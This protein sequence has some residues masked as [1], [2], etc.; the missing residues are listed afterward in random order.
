[1][2]AI[3][4][5]IRIISILFILFGL[6]IIYRLFYWQI[7]KGKQLSDIAQTQYF[8][9]TEISSSRGEILSS[10]GFPLVTNRRTYLLYALLN[11]IKK[12]P[13]EIAQKLSPF[14]TPNRSEDKEENKK[15]LKNTESSLKSQLMQQDLIWTVLGRRVLPED[16]EKIESLGIEG[17]GFEKEEIRFYPEASMAANLLGFV[18]KNK[19]GRDIGY[20]G[21][22]GFYD[23][24]LRG[25]PGIINQE[26]DA[27]NKP[28]LF[29]SFL[30]R[31]EKD[32]Q[33]LILHLDRAVQFTVEEK[34]QKA[35][36][37]YGA[38]SG[39]VIILDPETGGVLA[40]ASFPS[41]DP[42]KY[43]E[44]NDDLFKNPL[45]AETYEPGSTAK[46]LVTAAA[47][48]NKSI[49]KDDI[50][51]I[52]TGP[53]KIDKYTIRTWNDEYHP[54]STI[55]Q[56]IENSDNIGMI[57]IA[58]KLGIDSFWEYLKKFGFGEKTNI[59]LQEE[60]SGVLKPKNKWGEIDLATASFGQGIAIT[61]IQMARAV[62]AIANGGVLMEPHVV[63]KILDD[64]KEVNIKPKKI[65]EVIK[66]ESAREITDI[67]VN[68]VEKGE[69][70]WSKIKGYKIAGKTGTAQI[71][72]AGHYDEEKTIASFVGFAPAYKPKFVILV[73]LREPSSS[74]W[75]AETAA[76]L[77]FEITRN[78]LVYYGIQPE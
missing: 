6:V 53:V 67:M 46:V 21:L 44:E 12:T 13:T 56:I 64:K 63:S 71:P 28:I 38:K 17:L 61:G 35:I 45:I 51:P 42:V 37:K 39:S 75:A 3:Y 31:E 74:P 70:K 29:G 66:P 47:L 30:S 16:K 5:R 72:V 41:Y 7:L 11:K 78:L 69:A 36:S 48:D 33:T 60:I 34:L 2:D 22:E 52:C 57:F 32:G 27:G 76:P 77:F 73:K 20:F 9:Q 8:S 40:L 23:L 49:K 25:R 19:E 43:F 4:W 62:A 18:G 50:C 14:L 58:K 1:M 26:K 59:D 55:T 10:D 54:D 15:E 65:R 24:E 68:A